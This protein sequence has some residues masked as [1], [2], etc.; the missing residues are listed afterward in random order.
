MAMCEHFVPTMDTDENFSEYISYY[1]F[2]PTWPEQALI[3]STPHPE[4]TPAEAEQK[5]QWRQ[6]MQQERFRPPPVVGTTP[7]GDFILSDARVIKNVKN[8]KR[9]T[10]IKNNPADWESEQAR[11]KHRNVMPVRALLEA[12]RSEGS[13]GAGNNPGAT[14]IILS[15]QF[16]GWVRNWR[17]IKQARR[18][19]QRA[20]K[21]QLNHQIFRHVISRWV[22]QMTAESGR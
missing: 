5:E 16:G 2:T 4:D 7:E 22:R 19:Q 18:D 13:V 20:H 15:A 1:N 3:A 11:N 8:L 6:N 9:V 14:E 12:A 17:E 10:D 21:Q